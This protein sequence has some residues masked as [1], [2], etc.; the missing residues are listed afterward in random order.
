MGSEDGLSKVRDPLVALV[1]WIKSRSPKEKAYLLGMA[2]ILVS[3]RL[4][5]CNN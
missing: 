1:R 2:G 4:L 5:F 3:W